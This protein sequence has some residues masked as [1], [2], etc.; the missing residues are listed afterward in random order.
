MNIILGSPSS[1][2]RNNTTIY[3]L[4]RYATKPQIPMRWILLES[5]HGK[6][7]GDAVSAQMKRKMDECIAFNSNK[8]YEKPLDFIHAI[9]TSNYIHQ[10]VYL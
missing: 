10:T 6:G 4:N 8:L 5:E 1:Q 9:G 2:Y 7:I 3:M